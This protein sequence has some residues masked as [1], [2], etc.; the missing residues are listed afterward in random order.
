MKPMTEEHLAVLRRHMG[1]MIAIH[2]DLASE[3]I[4]KGAL[5]ERVMTALMRSPARRPVE[6]SPPSQLS[7]TPLRSPS[8]CTS[9]PNH[10][11]V[12]LQ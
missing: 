1:E 8:G 10:L 12:S 7:A 2:V 6:K 11:P 4:G 3:A 5:D 9:G